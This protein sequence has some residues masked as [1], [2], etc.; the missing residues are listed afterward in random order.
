MADRTVAIGSTAKTFSL[1]GW[2]IGYAFAPQNLTRLMR[3]VH[4]F[5]VFCSATPLQHGMMAALEL[6]DDY[7]RNFR[8]D[9]L[10][11]RD[12]L[13]NDLKAAGLKPLAPEGTYFIVADYSHLTKMDDIHFA[14]WLTDTVKVASIPLSPFY[15][16]HKTARQELH[17][18]RFAF[19]KGVATL[20]AAGEKLK[21]LKVI[22]VPSST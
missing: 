13:L 12:L 22:D 21:Q 16:D 4:Q 14:S 19:C 2:K 15:I 1:T 11:R 9:Y 8:T 7:Y 17:Y 6:G 18:L 3:A 10:E 20:H 5:T